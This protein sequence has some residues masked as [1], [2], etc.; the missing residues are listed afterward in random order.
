MPCLPTRFLTQGES[1]PGT[2]ASLKTSLK[3]L[4]VSGRVDGQGMNQRLMMPMKKHR[5]LAI[6]ELTLG[7]A[8]RKCRVPKMQGSLGEY[9]PISSR[10]AK[11]SGSGKGIQSGGWKGS[12]QRKVGAERG[13]GQ[14]SC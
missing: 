10:D 12:R 6:V 4:L 9:T 5:D 8:F 1:D 13:R 3:R 11:D 2:L 14:G 7:N